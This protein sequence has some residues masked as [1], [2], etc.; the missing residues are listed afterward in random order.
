MPLHSIT[1]FL[2]IFRLFYQA[3]ISIHTGMLFDAVYMFGLA[4]Q[5]ISNQKMSIS[6]FKDKITEFF[7]KNYTYNPGL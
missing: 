2:V 3:E 6:L 4:V 1:L 7:N 5:N